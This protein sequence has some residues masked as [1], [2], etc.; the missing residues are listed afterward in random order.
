MNLNDKAKYW[1]DLATEDVDVA[2]VLLGDGKLLYA[3]FMC[4]LI[5]KKGL[6]AI[7]ANTGNDV[8]P[9]KIHDLVQLAKQ[10]GIYA[11]MDDKQKG[12]IEILQPLNIEARYPAYKKNIAASLN[13]TRCKEIFEKTEGL[14]QW[15]SQQF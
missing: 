15:I 12:F 6:K 11:K 7:I 3:G 2:R 14:L 5:I 9:P 8:T 13:E 1:Y 4:H 10:G